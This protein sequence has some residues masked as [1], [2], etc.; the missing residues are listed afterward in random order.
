[1]SKQKSPERIKIEAVLSKH[2]NASIDFIVKESGVKDRQKISNVKGAIKVTAPK[3]RM[4]PHPVVSKTVPIV[5]AK[6][7]PMKMQMTLP[8]EGI[9]IKMVKNG[10]VLMTIV[11]REDGVIYIPNNAKKRPTKPVPYSFLKLFQESAFSIS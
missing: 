1:M 7:E 3:E 6:Q 11:L 8:S 5:P 9:E 2:P 10:G 4:I